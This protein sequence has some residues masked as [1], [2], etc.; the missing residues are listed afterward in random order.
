MAEYSQAVTKQKEEWDSAAD[1]WQ[2]NWTI[3][4]SGMETTTEFMLNIAGIRRREAT[5]L[6]LA[7]GIGEPALTFAERFPDSSVV[8]ID[9]SDNMLQ[10][11]RK[12]AAD[13]HIRNVIFFQAD[14]ATFTS[15]E[16]VFRRRPFDIVT[17]RH[18]LMFMPNVS[19][20]LQEVREVLG[21][22][23][24]F[25]AA[26]FGLPEEVPF[27]AKPM[28]ILA[29]MLN[30]PPPPPDAPNPFRFAGGEGLVE[31]LEK[32]GF[33]VTAT[34]IVRGQFH[35]TNGSQYV[36]FLQSVAPP[37]TGKLAGQ[38]PEIVKEYWRRVADL[39]PKSGGNM[40]IAAVCIA[41]R[42]GQPR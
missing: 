7:C 31:I 32:S 35:F 25:V 3:L 37:I 13:R 36:S 14:A 18:G 1:G 21:P 20:V 41:S 16:E 11:A 39:I 8:G 42:I 9:L 22:D 28:R 24:T 2:K 33:R 10:Y 6:D 26:A 23:G 30:M 27:L 15:V 19:A 4:H 29:N 17:C 34:G 12:N 5:I 40:T 38:S